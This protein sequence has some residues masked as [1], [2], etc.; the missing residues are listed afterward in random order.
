MVTCKPDISFSLIKLSQHSAQPVVAHF[1]ALQ[2]IFDYIRG[3]SSDG[4]YFWREMPRLNL[5]P[6]YMPQYKDNNN[7]KP[8]TCQQTDHL[9]IQANVDS[10]YAKIPPIDDQL[11][12][13]L[14]DS[15]RCSLL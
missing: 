5:P 2:S 11:W 7:H 9:Q 8:D 4:I 10:D 6:G 3:M 13:Y 12:A 15:G 14:S 1:D